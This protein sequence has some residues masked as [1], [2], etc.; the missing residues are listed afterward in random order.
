MKRKLISLSFIFLIAFTAVA[1][2]KNRSKKDPLAG[3]TFFGL[4]F[5][6]MHGSNFIRDENKL[7]QSDT[8]QY[9]INYKP[10]SYK[11]GAE[12]KHFFTYR[13]ALKTGLYYA[14]RKINVDY[15]S[16]HTASGLIKGL[17]DTTFTGQLHFTSYEIPIH[18]MGYVRLAKSIYMDIHGG[19]DL[20]FYPS[21]LMIDNIYLQR[22]GSFNS[23]FF[24][25]G[26]TF[27]VGWEWR[28]K[29]SGAFYLGASYQ[30]KGDYMGAVL[31]YEG[32]VLNAAEYFYELKGQYFS[33]DFRY[34]FNK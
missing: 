26:Y 1:Q 29:N 6:S 24:Q 20:N 16:E 10:F 7:F 28:T 14:Q 17:K 33:I 30:A 13:F 11:L 19:F 27:G 18:A 12:V 2:K 8:V 5:S 23:L 4:G 31:L 3:K 21:N 25:L 32:R 15:K 9:N 34:Y 22:E